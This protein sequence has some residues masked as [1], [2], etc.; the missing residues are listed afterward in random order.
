[1]NIN[2]NLWPAYFLKKPILSGGGRLGGTSMGNLFLGHLFK[3]LKSQI[4]VEAFDHNVL[5]F[6]EVLILYIFDKMDRNPQ[7]PPDKIFYKSQQ[8]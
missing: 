2:P 8:N 3:L 6:E 1:M 7:P 5:K 4:I